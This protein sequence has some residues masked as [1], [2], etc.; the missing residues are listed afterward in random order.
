MKTLSKMISKTKG[1][2]IM[3]EPKK[4]YTLEDNVKYISFTLKDLA[5]D[6][7]R[8]ADALSSIAK[9]NSNDTMPF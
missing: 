5:A 9:N 4:V 8:I 2:I 1:E 7:K 6:M 3:N